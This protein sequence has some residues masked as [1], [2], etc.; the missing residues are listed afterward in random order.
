M[1]IIVSCI[2]FTPKRVIQKLDNCSCDLLTYLHL[3]QESYN[4]SRTLEVLRSHLDFIHKDDWGLQREIEWL[5]DVPCSLTAKTE[6][7]ISSLLSEKNPRVDESPVSQLGS[8]PQEGG[9]TSQ[10]IFSSL[11]WGLWYLLLRV[12]VR[13]QWMH[14]CK[15]HRI[16][17]ESIHFNCF[18]YWFPCTTYDDQKQHSHH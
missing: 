3:F 16:V 14:S 10:S 6:A 2:K 12:V 4:I 7:Q 17:G 9:F 5:V 11:R 15:S 8:K 18:Y 1:G 13:I